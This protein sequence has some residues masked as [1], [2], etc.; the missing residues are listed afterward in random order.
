[1]TDT[2]DHVLISVFDS[3]LSEAA[4]ADH[5]LKGLS[6]NFLTFFLELLKMDPRKGEIE[7]KIVTRKT[8]NGLPV[9]GNLLK[10]D[11]AGKCGVVC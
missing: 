3:A 6:K 4:V 5:L 8:E 7:L 2:G 11:K 1:M 9:R 10:W